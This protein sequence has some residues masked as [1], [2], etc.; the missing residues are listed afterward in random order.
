MFQLT[1]TANTQTAYCIVNLA[2]KQTTDMKIYVKKNTNF[3]LQNM[4][5]PFGLFFYDFLCLENYLNP[6]TFQDLYVCL[7]KVENT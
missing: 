6:T 3:Q 2:V 1:I 7:A 4:Q 5:Q